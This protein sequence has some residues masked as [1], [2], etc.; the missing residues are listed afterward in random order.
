MLDKFTTFCLLLITPIVLGW[1]LDTYIKTKTKKHRISYYQI[2]PKQSDWIKGDEKYINLADGTL[3]E[4]ARAG[5]YKYCAMSPDLKQ[6]YNFGDSIMINI[7]KGKIYGVYTIHDLTS[8]RIHNTIDVLVDKDYYDRRGV[9]NKYV[10][11]I[12][13]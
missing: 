10:T 6:Y 4:V 3:V 13:D 8:P 11:K 9:H 12:N 7:E 1:V 5:E 2:D